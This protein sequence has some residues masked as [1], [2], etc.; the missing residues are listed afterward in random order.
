[1]SRFK[2]KYSIRKLLQDCGSLLAATAAVEAFGWKL[3]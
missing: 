1:V 3:N 2:I